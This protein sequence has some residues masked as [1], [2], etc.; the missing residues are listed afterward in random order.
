MQTFVPTFSKRRNCQ[1]LLLYIF[2]LFVWGDMAPHIDECVLCYLCTIFASLAFIVDASVMIYACIWFPICA[3]V[4]V[5]FVCY[6]CVMH[7]GGL[8]RL[9]IIVF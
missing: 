3:P 7:S 4:G 5:L 6:A 2:H 9:R 1:A 8:S